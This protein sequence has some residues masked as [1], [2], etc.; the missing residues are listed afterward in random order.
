MPPRSG[1]S[2]ET[3][4]GPGSCP[5]APGA[6]AYRKAQ[7]VLRRRL[8]GGR[9]KPCAFPRERWG[10][11]VERPMAA[12]AEA[13]KRGAVFLELRGRRGKKP[14]SG[15]FRRQDPAAK[16]HTLLFI[17]KFGISSKGARPCSARKGKPAINRDMPPCFQGDHRIPVFLL[18]MV[19][20]WNDG[21][22][23]RPNLLSRPI[24]SCHMF[25]TKCNQL[26]HAG[27]FEFAAIITPLAILL[28]KI[29][30]RLFADCSILQ[31]HT[32]ALTD[33]L[34]G[35]TQQGVD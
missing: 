1:N 29:A 20:L 5:C 34:S 11:P 17:T 14:R 9:P 16:R 15:R 32:T 27:I 2:A 19:Q 30:I 12:M 8:P 23:I 25:C 28:I 26:L 4:S 21:F 31:W 22:H 18:P 24:L 3:G 35:R 33:K 6:I 10:A 13:R 7:T